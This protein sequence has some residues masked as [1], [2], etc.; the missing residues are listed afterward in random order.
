MRPT[1]QEKKK[2]ISFKRLLLIEN[3]PGHSRAL[4]E[5]YYEIHVFM[6]ANPTSILPSMDQGVILNSESYYLRNIFFKAIAAIDSDFP[7][8]SGDISSK[9]SNFQVN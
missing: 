3:A 8:I 4:M 7:D 9:F 6:L 1:P 2:K 5:M